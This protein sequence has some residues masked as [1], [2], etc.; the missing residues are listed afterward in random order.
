MLGG[1]SV[2]DRVERMRQDM[3]NIFLMKIGH[4]IEN[5]FPYF[6]YFYMLILGDIDRQDMRFAAIFW[7]RGRHLLTDEKTRQMCDFHC[8]IDGVVIRD[9]D[10]R[11][12]PLL[13]YRVDMQGLSKTLWATQLL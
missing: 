11:H 3:K 5:I 8:A 13:G 6:L 12:A 4:K 7:K 9:G 10:M 2:I 1:Q